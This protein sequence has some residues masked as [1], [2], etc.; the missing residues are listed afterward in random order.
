MKAIEIAAVDRPFTPVLEKQP[1]LLQNLTEVTSLHFYPENIDRLNACQKAL[2]SHTEIRE[3]QLSPGFQNLPGFNPQDLHDTS[4]RSGL[5]F[6]TIFSH[7]IPLE[8]CTPIRLRKLTIDNIDVRYA[9]DTYMKAIDFSCLES[10][11][12]GGCPGIDALFSRM[13]KPHV[14]PNSLKKIRWFHEISEEPH[15]LEAFEGLLEGLLGLEIIHVD[16][17]NIGALPKPSAITHHSKTLK[18]LALRSRMSMEQSNLDTLKCYD[19][20]EFNEI[21]TECSELRQL[22]IST[23]KTDVSKAKPSMEFTTFLVCML[24]YPT[25]AAVQISLRRAFM[26]QRKWADIQQAMRGETPLSHNT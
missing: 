7:M 2:E 20:D 5:I 19:Q 8:D 9:A 18:V 1:E 17:R 12:I 11:V 3:M 14:R 22:S 10:L 6:R 21:T 15:A 24:P 25:M 26:S 23:P 16:I 4:T 13:S